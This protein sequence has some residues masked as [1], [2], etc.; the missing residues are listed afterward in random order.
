MIK[1]IMAVD[2]NGG[3]SKGSSM[4]WPKNSNDLNW[5]KNTENIQKK[6]CIGILNSRGPLALHFDTKRSYVSQPVGKIWTII[7]PRGS[8][9]AHFWPK[10]CLKLCIF[11]KNLYINYCFST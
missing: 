8:K 11:Y 1:A 5:F 2:D 7:C 6:Y 10:Q 4:P 9:I 3:I